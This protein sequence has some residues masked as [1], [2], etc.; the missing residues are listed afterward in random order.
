MHTRSDGRFFNITKL[1]AKTKV[2]EII[3]RNMLFAD[4]TA[5]TSHTEQLLMNYELLTFK[6][7]LITCP[8]L[9]NTAKHNGYES[10]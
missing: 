10:S 6:P 9:K 2:H 8:K 1:R 4:D 7:L 3:I 5:V